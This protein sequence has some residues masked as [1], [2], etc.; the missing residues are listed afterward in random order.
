MT[1]NEL[2][3]DVI[4]QNLDMVKM[5]LADFSDADMLVR[6]VPGANH[7]AWQIAHLAS[8]SANM[9]TAMSPDV[10]VNL[11]ENFA[12][13]SDKEAAKSDDPARFPRKAELLRVLEMACNAQISAIG[14]LSGDD[15]A[16]ASPERVRSFAPTLGHLAA[17]GPQH[18]N[19]HVGQIQVIR[20]KL[21]KPVL[22]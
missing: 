17:L 7:A 19:M 5:H 16:K 10:T 12:K 9:A 1:Q 4:R 3:A 18:A 14:K 15:F 2:L 21:G 13:S 20:R 8:S 11:P 6:P 22:F